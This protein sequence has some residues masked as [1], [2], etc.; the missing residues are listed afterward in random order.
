MGFKIDLMNVEDFIKKYDAQEVTTGK[1]L[2]SYGEPHPEGLL[3]YEIFGTP[4]SED[5][6]ELYGYIDL[7]FNFVHPHVLYTISLLP[8]G[9]NF[10]V[11]LIRGEVRAY[12]DPETHLLKKVTNEDLIPSAAESG[13]GAN[14]LFD[15]WKKIKLYPDEFDYY[16][17]DREESIKFIKSL[18]KEEFF[19]NK[20]VVIPAFY[21]D[22][23]KEK[24]KDNELNKI[25]RRILNNS[26]V[27][28]SM[29]SL[30][31]VDDVPKSY[32]II[33]DSLTELYDY[34]YNIIGGNK[35]YIH[36]AVIG[37]TTD[38]SAR[39]IIT[40]PN[41]N[42]W[43]TTV[44]YDRVILPLNSAIKCFAPFIV[45]GVKRVLTL[46]LGESPEFTFRFDKETKKLVRDKLKLPLMEYWNSDM[47][48]DKIE[49]FDKSKHHRFDPAILPT[50]NDSELPLM[51]I[52][53]ENKTIYGQDKLRDLFKDNGDF[54]YDEYL[55]EYRPLT[56]FELFYL[57]TK[58]IED[59]H[60]YVTRYPVTSYSS[61][62]PTKF[63]IIPFYKTMELDFLSNRY[64]F[65][66]DLDPERDI[67]IIDEVFSDSLQIH[68]LYLTALGADFDGDQVS[69]QGVFTDEANND[70]EK[71]MLSNI[72]ISDV[73]GST[74]R[75]LKDVAIHTLYNI[76]RDNKNS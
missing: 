65:F 45:Y 17:P 11:P 10:Y 32:I 69:V 29:K 68:P 31:V 14:F 73:S 67:K 40:M 8:N 5:R 18:K 9:R 1:S 34:F 46:I 55:N 60:I 71:A 16:S 64:E 48:Y 27:L 13:T 50:E 51:M 22:L 49:L 41:F 44:E 72:N 37:K 43:D 53:K 4:G 63:K 62:Y 52:H 61:I 59:K 58:A 12:I 20:W 21:R 7:G 33:M 57:A 47:I 42:N 70:A 26:S 35:G 15:N 76:T 36:K 66:P 28:K 75:L 39:L 74:N 3:S 23:D 6:K 2:D 30:Y 19:V 38:F 25:Y 54:D 24:G 56:M